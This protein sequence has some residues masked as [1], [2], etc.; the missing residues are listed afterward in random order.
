VDLIPEERLSSEDKSVEQLKDDLDYFY[1]NFPEKL[2]RIKRISSNKLEPLKRFHK[3]VV[4]VLRGDKV[5]REKQKKMGIV[6]RGADYIKSALK[7]IILENSINGLSAENLL[8]NIEGEPENLKDTAGSYEFKRSTVS[9]KDMADKMPVS[10][11][12]PTTDIEQ[13]E[14]SS[15]RY[16]RP[17]ARLPK[18]RAVYFRPETV[19]KKMVA[20]NPF[21]TARQPKIRLKYSY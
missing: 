18:Q 4:A 14:E 5:E 15:A 10:R 16:K 2:R 20:D 19:A 8:V 12:I 11:F 9:G 21:L 13:V 3:R 6:I 17:I 7:E 1:I